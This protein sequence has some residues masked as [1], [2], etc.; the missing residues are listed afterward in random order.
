MMPIMPFQIASAVA[1]SMLCKGSK[2][3]AVIGTWVSN[4]LNWYFLYLY[5]SKIGAQL[6]GLPEKSVISSSIMSAI[7][8]GE[9]LMIIA[10]KIVGA[11]SVIVAAFLLGGLIMGII[12]ATPS[13]FVFLHL[14]KYIKSLRAKRKSR[15]A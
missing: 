10:G 8:S 11:G 13:Y 15:K 9:G 1:C 14:F 6:L 5:S 7:K 4:P 12:L 3:T 2:I